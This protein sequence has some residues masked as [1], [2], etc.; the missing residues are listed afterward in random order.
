MTLGFIET[1]KFMQI[2]EIYFAGD[3]SYSAL[4]QTLLSTPEI[5]DV[6]SGCGGLRKMRWPD[7]RRGKGKRGGLRVIYLYVQEVQIILFLSVYDKDKADDLTALERK[8]LTQ[9]AGSLR[10]SILQRQ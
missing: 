5:G 8:I 6:M 9:L 10:E 1:Q 7:P 4:Q 2:R 3:A